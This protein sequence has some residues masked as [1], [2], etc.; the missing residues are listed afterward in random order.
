[1]AQQIPHHC[2]QCGSPLVPQQRFCARCGTSIILPIPAQQEFSPARSPINA[3]AFSDQEPP[4][5]FT[6]QKRMQR[7]TMSTQSIPGPIKPQTLQRRRFGPVGIIL[8]GLAILLLLGA[9]GFVVLPLLGIGRATQAT[10]AISSLHTT[11]SYDGADVQIQD[12][13]Q[14]ANFV[15]DPHSASNGML[16]LHLQAVNRTKSTVTLVY[17]DIAHVV[18]T[19]GTEV[20]TVYVAGNPVLAAGETK[21][22]TLDFAVPATMK[23]DQLALRLGTQAE[24]R[25]DIP[26]TAH[27]DMQKYAPKTITVNQLSTYRSLNYQVKEA[28]LERSLDGKLAPRGMSYVGVNFT[29]ANPLSQSVVV[30]SPFDYLRLQAA[31][32]TFTPQ[33]ATAPISVAANVQNQIGSAVFLVPQHTSSFTLIL[34]S[35][36]NDGFDKQSVN[37]S[38]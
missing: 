3:S 16:R 4:A 5:H 12:A 11:V 30:G 15:D 10:I 32:M 23:I 22:S 36:S 14:S 27:A 25:L 6:A 38:F 9:L 8:L 17:N 26:L 31:N 35:Q 19:N 20:N 28:V 24:A 2:P 21:A 34:A 18:L 37:F 13:Q 29:I 7:P 33:Q 1:M